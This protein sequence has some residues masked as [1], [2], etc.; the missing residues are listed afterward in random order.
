MANIVVYYTKQQMEL[1][2]INSLSAGELED[3]KYLEGLEG[4]W[5]TEKGALKVGY[6]WERYLIYLAA[7]CREG[8]YLV[9]C[10]NSSNAKDESGHYFVII[11]GVAVSD[12]QVEVKKKKV[13]KTVDLKREGKLKE[14]V[15]SMLAFASCKQFTTFGLQAFKLVK[16]DPPPPIK[17]KGLK[18]QASVALLLQ[19]ERLEQ[20]AGATVTTNTGKQI[21]AKSLKRQAA[22][23]R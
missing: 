17:E 20:A 8:R 15:R 6:L 3:L 19:K 7:T 5:N 12:H 4:G 1:K 14:S 11:D 23:A 16:K 9:Y 18:R 22:V 2:E 21:T 13:A 10:W